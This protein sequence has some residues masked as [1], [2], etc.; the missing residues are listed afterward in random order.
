M[1]WWEVPQEHNVEGWWCVWNYVTVMDIPPHPHP[2]FVPSTVP[3]PH[4]Q[5]WDAS[6][7]FPL[8]LICHPHPKT[9]LSGKGT[10]HLIPRV[11]V[12]WCPAAFAWRP[13]AHLAGAFLGQ[14]VLVQ[15]ALVLA[16]ELVA[17]PHPLAVFLHMRQ[18]WRADQLHDILVPGAAAAWASR[19]IAGR[20]WPRGSPLPVLPQQ[21][22]ALFPGQQLPQ[23][24]PRQHFQRDAGQRL[25][26]AMLPGPADVGAPVLA[27]QP[28]E[29]EPLLSLQH[30]LV[31]LYLQEW[32]RVGAAILKYLNS[33]WCLITDQSSWSSAWSTVIAMS[34]L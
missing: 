29:Q 28:A 26:K 17:A 14:P 2:E 13:V 20:C 32:Q 5:L 10:M 8:S 3:C 9:L 31:R 27:G 24:L 34:D 11:Q 4:V 33:V 25:R 23:R 22:R 30:T 6:V 19:G 1:V 7:F 21:L 15:D 16:P 12:T 18:A